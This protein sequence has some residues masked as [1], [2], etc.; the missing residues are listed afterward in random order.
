MICK[1]NLVC[2]ASH[3]LGFRKYWTGRTCNRAFAQASRLRTMASHDGVEITPV[4]LR[5]RFHPNKQLLASIS[6]AN[7]CDQ[8]IAYKIKT[9]APKKYLVR[10]S[11]GIVELKS[12]ATSIQVV[13]MAHKTYDEDMADCKDKFMI[14][15]VL[16][17]P[18]E[19]IT[20]ATFNKEVRKSDI[21]EA[22]LRVIVEGP[23]T[24]AQVQEEEQE[25]EP[26]N[27]KELRTLE[28]K[29][30]KAAEQQEKLNALSKDLAEATK[31]NKLLT[32]CLAKTEAERD[33]LRRTLD[34]VQ[35]QQEKPAPDPALTLRVS[36]VH[37]ILAAIVAFLIGH[38]L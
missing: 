5:F 7:S 8:R 17:A 11:S 30:L 18:G 29:N 26:L 27:E 35:L 2:E 24:P 32:T 33:E 25:E 34:Q 1:A 21:R 9:T 20:E 38:Y 23:P 12:S 37:I 22:R 36:L 15:T 14:Q 28:L 31:A 3:K 10:P 16:L 13:M 6:I 19:E 4:E